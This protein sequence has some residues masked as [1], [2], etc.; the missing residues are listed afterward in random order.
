[1]TVLQGTMSD[2]TLI[3]VQA[4]SQGRLVCEG[5]QGPEGPQ[6]PPGVGELPPNPKNGD[7]LAWDNGLV[8]VSGVIPAGP[9]WETDEITDVQGI[10][11]PWS[12]FLSTPQGF[13]GANI[14]KNGKVIGLAAYAFDGS[15]DHMCATS[16]DSGD[17]AIKFAP[18]VAVAVTSSFRIY[19]GSNNSTPDNFSVSTGGAG[20]SFS[21]DPSTSAWFSIP[22]FVGATI[23]ADSPLIMANSRGGQNTMVGGIEIDGSVLVNNAFLPQLTFASDKNLDKFKQGDVINQE[24][25]AASGTVDSVD[26]AAK[27]ITLATSTGTWGPANAGHYG[28]SAD[29]PVL[30]GN[31]FTP[32]R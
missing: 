17:K 20:K 8:W 24:D 19:C 30:Y 16:A 3:P 1:M 18:P 10:P 13:Q 4:D 27:T 7:V 14:S 28:I 31:K 11:V 26:I 15:T 25:S 9:P 32:H 29:I 6:G 12:N 21:I 5:L 2:G 22:E 23:S